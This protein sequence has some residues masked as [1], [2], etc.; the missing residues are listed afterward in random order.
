VR[1]T[2]DADD[3]RTHYVLVK[4]EDGKRID[5]AVADVL[6]FQAAMTMPPP[7]DLSAGFISFED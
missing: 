3:G 4:G 1:I 2:D 7:V 5:A 6:A